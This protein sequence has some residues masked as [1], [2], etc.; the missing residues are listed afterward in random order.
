MLV[1]GVPDHITITLKE[2]IK[3]FINLL[4]KE[5]IDIYEENKEFIRIYGY[6]CRTLFELCM[7]YLHSN[8]ID[9][10]TATGL[11]HT[12]FKNIINKYIKDENLDILDYTDNIRKIDKK[13]IKNN[14][15][16]ITHLFGQ[17]L[18]LSN[19]REE[20][21]KNKNLLIIED[22][23]QGGSLNKVFS[24]DIIDISIYSMGMDK[25][26]NSM[27]GGFINIRNNEKFKLLINYLINKTRELKRETRIE[28]LCNLIKKIPTFLIYNYNLFTSPLIYTISFLKYLNPNINTGTITRN[29][30]EINPGFTHDNYMKQPSYPLLK[31]IKENL[32]NHL[33]IE[34]VQAVKNNK[35]M[36]MLS[37][38]IKNNNY[39]WYN[40]NNLLTNYNTIYMTNNKINNFINICNNKNICVIKN[41]TYKSLNKKY[42]TLCNNLIYLPSLNTLN[43]KEMNYLVRV[44]EK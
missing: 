41:P 12:S 30:R 28:R 20:K 2:Y 22:R 44:L 16:L 31:S 4:T 38:T 34:G 15:V 43:D 14:I 37:N 39:P 3:L 8:K 17:D 26:P 40:G 36:N 29:Y 23:V 11:Q 25:R 33:K 19:L 35:Y 32:N 7:L 42:E 6:S 13:D 5:K 21:E 18:D 1:S 24:D 27:G 10:I 9:K